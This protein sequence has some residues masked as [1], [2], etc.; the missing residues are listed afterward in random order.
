MRGRGMSRRTPSLVGLRR[1]PKTSTIWGPGSPT[2][3][4]GGEAIKTIEGPRIAIEIRTDP[5]T[6]FETNMGGVEQTTEPNHVIS[7][8]ADLLL[9]FD[10][11]EGSSAFADSSPTPKVV[12]PNGGIVQRAAAAVFGAS[13]CRFVA[14]SNQYLSLADDVAW[15]ILAN[16][17]NF[18]IE[19]WART[20]APASGQVLL[21]HRQDDNNRWG[22]ANGTVG[23][24]SLRFYVLS[25]GVSVLA[26]D[27]ANGVLDGTLSCFA[28]ERYAGNVYIYKNGVLVASTAFTGSPTFAGPLNIGSHDGTSYF[29][30]GDMDELVVR[31]GANSHGANYT[32]LSAAYRD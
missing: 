7:L 8:P 31:R 1:S 27:T 11:G 28:V 15:D 13:G 5:S 32:P 4:S 18:F 22:F 30:D 12:T 24:G 20:N 2:P 16:G 14:A 3:P 25:G 21:T 29:F 19:M 10:G 26:L 23:S 6:D 9:H 17:E